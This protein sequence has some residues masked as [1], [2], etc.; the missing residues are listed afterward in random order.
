MNMNMS[1]DE[2]LV[3]VL[4]MLESEHSAKEI[5][6]TASVKNFWEARK[7]ILKHLEAEQRIKEE[8]KL[9]ETMARRKVMSKLSEQQKIALGLKRGSIEV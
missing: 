5:L 6:N 7:A 2:L 9:K 1:T 4:K 3:T 8:R